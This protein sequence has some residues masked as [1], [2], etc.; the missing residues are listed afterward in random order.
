MTP[1][2]H[3]LLSQIEDTR[4]RDLAQRLASLRAALADLDRAEEEVRARM[5]ALA[6]T[7]QFGPLASQAARHRHDLRTRL[8]EMDAARA[9]L[10]AEAEALNA[11]LVDAIGRQTAG[12]DIARAQA[13]LQRRRA[14]ARED[15]ARDLLAGAAGKGG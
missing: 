1:P 13:A 9:T 4:A 6:E 5:R 12:D 11:S 14:L 7:P 10:H 15:D 3:V 8:A 2:A